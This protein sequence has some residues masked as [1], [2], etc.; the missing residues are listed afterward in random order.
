VFHSA[1]LLQTPG[2]AN[3]TGVGP[4]AAL[5][6]M[7][8]VDIADVQGTLRIAPVPGVELGTLTL[9]LRYF[10]DSMRGRLT[11]DFTNDW[12]RQDGTGSN[13]L[14]FDDQPLVAR[15]PADDCD[16]EVQPAP[17]AEPDLRLLG[18][19]PS[20]HLAALRAI[21]ATTDR[22]ASWIGMGQQ[23]ALLVELGT[24]QYACVTPGR[25][26]NI[27]LR[28]STSDGALDW[29]VLAAHDLADEST[30]LPHRLS[31]SQELDPLSTMW[32]EVFGAFQHAPAS[33]HILVRFGA[34]YPAT[35]GPSAAPGHAALAISESSMCNHH[36]F[37]CPEAR[38]ACLE[39]P[40]GPECLIGE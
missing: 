4:D 30:H 26:S 2:P 27:P 37:A 25:I 16:L 13:I 22:T 35:S 8:G 29:S 40:P 18:R 32:S 28:L 23:T 6:I 36:L 14:P 5:S 19:S 9:V 12:L 33:D 31:F 24:P 20:E 38:A 1:V 3:P 17:L 15:F 10:A 34:E 39:S 11:F 7:A 21:I